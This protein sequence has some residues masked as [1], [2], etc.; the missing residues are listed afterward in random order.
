MDREEHLIMAMKIRGKADSQTKRIAA[1]LGGYE[2]LHPDSIIEVYR[3]NSASIRI[4]IIDDSFQGVG[5]SDRHDDVWHHLDVLSDE[6]L[7]SV[8]VLLLITPEEAKDSFMNFN[9]EHP[10]RS[11]L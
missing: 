7:S 3:Q 9:F 8:S 1:A 6:D 10:V 4:R 11:R 5:L 2:R